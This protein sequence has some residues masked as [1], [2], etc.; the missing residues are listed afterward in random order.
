MGSKYLNMEERQEIENMVSSSRIIEKSL[1]RAQD[2]YRNGMD[3]LSTAIGEDDLK[4]F[5]EWASYKM[6]SIRNKLS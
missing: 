6:T 4:W 3:F 2:C 5:D 1:T